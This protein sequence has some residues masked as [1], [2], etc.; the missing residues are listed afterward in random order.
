MSLLNHTLA[1]L[2][3]GRERP[4]QNLTGGRRN[5]GN[6]GNSRTLVVNGELVI[7]TI[8]SKFFFV[9]SFI[10]FLS[11]SISFHMLFK[12]SL[13][14]PSDGSVLPGPFLLLLFASSLFLLVLRLPSCCYPSS[15]ISRSS[16][17]SSIRLSQ[18]NSEEANPTLRALP[19]MMASN[20]SFAR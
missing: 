20:A 11:L 8:L 9:F 18:S 12:R 5:F 1:P 19:S 3:G 16:P 6:R 4:A 7:F 14:S 15:P 10:A 13:L 2:E 17:S